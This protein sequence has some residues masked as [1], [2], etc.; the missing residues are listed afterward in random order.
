ML[1]KKNK[2]IIGTFFLG[3]LA[4]LFQTSVVFA[5]TSEVQQ[6]DLLLKEQITMELVKEEVLA[7][8]KQASF[9]EIPEIQLLRVK[10]TSKA[11]AK[12]MEDHE[13]IE[14]AGN[15]ADI[16]VED[17]RIIQQKEMLKN[18]MLPEVAMSKSTVDE[19]DV[20]DQLAWY[21]ETMVGSGQVFKKTT[22][23][24]VQIG[25]IDSG[26]DVIHPL[27]APV[28]DL[29][30]AKS[31]ID[32]EPSIKDENG[33]G[34]MVAGAIAQLAPEAT[35][36]P[37]RVLSATDG[38]SFWTLA[39]MIQAVNDQQDVLNMSLG[40]YKFA[41]VAEEKITIESF[42]RAVNYALEHNVVIVSSSGNKGLDLDWEFENEGLRHLPGSVPGVLATSALTQENSLASYSN[43]GSNVQQAAPGGDYIYVGGM[44]DISE[45][46]YTSYPLAMD[47]GLES[48]GIPR[49]YMFTAGTSL[50]APCVTGIIADYISFYQKMTGARPTIERIKEDVGSTSKELS[51]SGKNKFYGHGLPKIEAAI[52][53]VSNTIP[54]TGTFKIQTLEVGQSIPAAEFV[55][56][57]Q[58]NTEEEITIS[59]LKEPKFSQLGIQEVIVLLE[60]VSGNQTELSGNV[61]IV[62]TRPPAGTFVEQTVEVNE[63]NQ[64]KAY[65]KDI[66][67]YSNAGVTISFI[68]E[69]KFNQLGEQEVIIQLED[70]SGN[71]TRLSG[72]VLIRDTIPP[73]ATFKDQKITKGEEVTPEMFI[74]QVKD[75]YDEVKDIQITFVNPV[76]TNKLGS[77]EITVRLTDTSGNTTILNGQ[78]QV[79]DIIS[80]TDIEKFNTENADTNTSNKVLTTKEN[81]SK[82]TQLP[83]TSEKVINLFNHGSLLIIISILLF[84]WRV[85]RKN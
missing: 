59:Y 27:L 54:P 49:G 24:G 60:D 76:D 52:N 40:S 74:E 36:T 29:T 46:F 80:E 5:D 66:T 77:Q 16:I 37:Y 83:N 34:T 31:F 43:I 47:N 26:V 30:K 79:V 19:F 39:A 73:T 11:I 12:T 65:V 28:V 42:E 82:K 56:D 2:F 1:F 14:M 45:L 3:F 6:I 23:Q 57:I 67:D 38:E 64:A 70:G 22:G 81:T 8:D 18:V 78:L 53:K 68:K 33:H 41:N 62:N 10:S 72:N 21:K 13:T 69:P 75:N 9:E 85:K 58:S 63:P 55:I 84:G 20:L 50:A 25:L 17:K 51:G 35:I 32:G 71:K 44:L 7:I 48:L 4:I 61:T 15:L